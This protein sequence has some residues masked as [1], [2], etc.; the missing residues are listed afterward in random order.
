MAL[1]SRSAQAQDELHRRQ[2]AGSSAAEIQ[3]FE[4]NVADLVGKRETAHVESTAIHNLLDS[5]KLKL[6]Q[7]NRQLENKGPDQS[8][9]Q[10]A[11]AVLFAAS[12]DVWVHT[13]AQFDVTFNGGVAFGSL[14]D[15]HYFLKPTQ[16]GSTDTTVEE[17]T[18]TRDQFRPDLAIFATVR[19]P[20]RFAG[21]GLSFGFGAGSGAAARFF[22]GPSIVFGQNLILTGGV[23]AGKVA[24]LPVGQTISQ[25]PINGANTLNQLGSQYQHGY[26]LGIAFLF[27]NRPKSDFLGPLSSG[28][29]TDQPDTAAPDLPAY[30]GTYT[31]DTKKV[32]VTVASAK[33]HVVV[34]GFDKAVDGDLQAASDGAAGSYTDDSGGNYVF[35]LAKGNTKA[36]LAYTPK[37]GTATTLTKSA[38]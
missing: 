24:V 14:R 3:S 12:F 18:D 37:D 21:L 4:A 32:V 23:T 15:H 19:N 5:E 27:D 33:L 31:N 1:S 10:M 9:Q 35:V 20:E 30:V 2:A 16:P 6:D 8:E 7:L 22:F 25:P 13:A 26:F 17:D 38:S 29:S 34:T 28:Q 36:K 11:Q